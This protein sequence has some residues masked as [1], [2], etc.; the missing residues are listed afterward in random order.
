MKRANQKG[1][2]LITVVMSAV[3]IVAVLAVTI[4]AVMQGSKPKETV[5]SNN[6]CRTVAQSVIRQLKSNGTQAK[7][8]N[9]PLGEDSVFLDDGPWHAGK[10]L[11]NKGTIDTESGAAAD[12]RWPHAKVLTW[13][14][15]KATYMSHTPLLIQGAMNGLASL[16]QKNSLFC[17][18]ARGV[19][20]G[21]TEYLQNL[22]QDE[23]KNKEI[24]AF[25]KIRPYDTMSGDLVACDQTLKVR[26]RALTE[27]P[28]A[29]KIGMMDFGDYVSNRGFEVTVSVDVES[30]RAVAREQE[31]VLA[32]ACEIKA[33]FQ[34]DQA[35]ERPQVPD[36]EQS[37]DTY[38]V[39]KSPGFSAPGTHLMCKEEHFYY[40]YPHVS[41]R[42]RTASPM[43]STG[44]KVC[45][46]VTVCGLK[47]NTVSFDDEIGEIKLEFPAIS[48]DCST[49]FEARVI[50]VAGNTSNIIPFAKADGIGTPARAVAS[51]PSSPSETSDEP[52]SVE[53]FMVAGSTFETLEAAELASFHSGHRIKEISFTRW[54]KDDMMKEIDQVFKDTEA[55]ADEH[56]ASAA[57]LSSTAEGIDS[58]DPALMGEKVIE[59]EQAVI[60]AQAAFVAA[61]GNPEIIRERLKFWNEKL[62]PPGWGKHLGAI[63]PSVAFNTEK[64]LDRLEKSADGLGVS[65]LSI[66]IK[67]LQD[68]VDAAQLSYDAARDSLASCRADTVRHCD[69]P[70]EYG[71]RSCKR[72]PRDCTI[73][74]SSAAAAEAELNTAKANV[75]AARRDR[76]AAKAAYDAK[77]K[78]VA[79]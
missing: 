66:K 2:A 77:W 43:V 32:A 4:P 16:S 40:I 21:A 36:F 11:Y 59:A 65:S 79:A 53:A 48:N 3:A 6:E 13:D 67:A 70:D 78:E 29:Q 72:V 52:S 51:V 12:K 42:T 27:P 26:P 57:A 14:A 33:R 44:W 35:R 17:S 63:G 64:E 61:E 7:L 68:K 31:D 1:E 23:I 54:P 74:E 37:G 18:G 75:E 62:E 73:Q 46:A 60:E 56:E 76:D 47:P 41:R 20:I 10:H 8:H 34:Y 71:N 58:V 39:R 15:A 28:A 30:S 22:V 25:I 38:T 55:L 69:P 49:S 24:S 5:E 19:E 50:D 9:P 45:D